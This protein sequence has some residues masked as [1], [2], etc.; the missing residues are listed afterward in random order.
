MKARKPSMRFF[1]GIGRLIF[2]AGLLMSVAYTNAATEDECMELFTKSQGVP[3][4]PSCAGVTLGTMPLTGDSENPY[5]PINY[6]N[7][8][9][10]VADYCA[11]E[12]G[13]APPD[14]TCPV[15]DPVY[16]ASGVV[17]ATEND[18][19]SGD[20]IPFVFTRTYR[21]VPYPLTA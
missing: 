6:Y 10:Y 2:A 17:T 7:C 3:G 18:F 15:A 1:G 9:H 8:G 11:G 14:A 13:G 16:A 5:S 12:T 19:V 21:S 4:T 20:E